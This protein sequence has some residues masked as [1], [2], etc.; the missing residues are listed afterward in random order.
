MD[1]DTAITVAEFCQRYEIGKTTVYKLI[2]HGKLRTIKI[3]R[4]RRIPVSAIREWQE[5]AEAPA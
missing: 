4:C 2:Q 1:T 3:G 5:R